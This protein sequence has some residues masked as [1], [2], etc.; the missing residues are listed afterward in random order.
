VS[1]D[2]LEAIYPWMPD[3]YA[4]LRRIRASHVEQEW[5]NVS[6]GL[7][8]LIA[9][10]RAAD[11]EGWDCY[12]GVL[13]RIRPSGKAEDTTPTTTVLWADL[14]NKNIGSHMASLLSLQSSGMEPSILVDSGNGL[15]AYWLLRQPIP[16]AK[17][18]AA[19]QGLHKLIG[20]D[21]VHDAPRVLRLPGTRNHKHCNHDITD[22]FVEPCKP[23]RLLRLDT[24]R[25]YRWA[26][27]ADFVPAPPPRRHQVTG[28]ELGRQEYHEL[29]QW[30]REHIEKGAP[31]GQ[32]SEL[33]WKVI[34]NLLERGW[35][36]DE[37]ESLF[38]VMA[39]GEKTQE[40]PERA[41]TRY[42][43]RTIERA[44]EVIE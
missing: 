43:R 14:D 7:D 1:K 29:P 25:R 22:A 44:R 21:S 19:M 10:A 33:I 15:H 41:A 18:S 12:I 35:E 9:R 3:T 13:P 28:Y 31:Q 8:I 39:I 38:S 4:E 27:F 17:A 30:L 2:F 40:M 34:C 36:E 23:V 20:S 11:A 42:L 24:T 37:I 5:F 26:D 6:G 32:R 16:F